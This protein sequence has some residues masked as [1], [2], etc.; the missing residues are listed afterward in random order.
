VGSGGVQSGDRRSRAGSAEPTGA[1]PHASPFPDTA[2]PVVSSDPSVAELVATLPLGRGRLGPGMLRGVTE[3]F[4]ARP[5]T[6]SERLVPTSDGRVYV[7]LFRCDELEVWL[8]GW[9][10]GQETTWHDHGGSSGSFRVVEGALLEEFRRPSGTLGRRVLRVGEGA[11]FG[12]GY[13]HNVIREQSGPALSIHAYS[14]ALHTMTYF[15]PT[16]LGLAA[17]ETRVVDGP[18]DLRAS[19]T[20][21]R[22]PATTG[23]APT[24]R[25]DYAG[26][27]E[28]PRPERGIATLLDAARARLDRL[29]PLEAA[30]AVAEGAVLVDTRPLAQR[31]ADGEVPG[32]VVIERNVLEWR[33]EPSSDARLPWATSPELRV[34]VM[35]DEGYASSLA[36][37]SL[38]DLGLRHA[39]DLEGGFQAWRAAGLPVRPALVPPDLLRRAAAA[40]VAGGGVRA[41][42]AA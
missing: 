35:C 16:A 26:A 20:P 23:E 27:R 3:L 12:P 14:P 29:G 42:G 32:A 4:A 2:R 41:D 38:R 8:L 37:A 24:G 28:V 25:P 9:E 17:V 1:V 15:R 40:G 39:T 7:R 18:D 30:A 6:W 21:L 10:G 19:T 11:S 36:A 13:A 33:L 34:I 31:L 22:E 5:E